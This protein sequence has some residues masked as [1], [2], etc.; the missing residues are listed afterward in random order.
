MNFAFDEDQDRLRDSA[1]R[2]LRDRI[3]LNRL[4]SQG[5]RPDTTYDPS[6]WRDIVALGWPGLL[7]PEEYGGL[8]MSLVDWVVVTEELGRALAPCPYLGTYAGT[9]ALLRAG[10]TDQKERLLPQVVSGGAQL[11]LAWS[12]T[13]QSEDP[14]AVA[15]SVK[16]GVLRGSKRY[17]ID[18]DT[19]THFVVTAR[20]SSGTLGF[21]LVERGQPGVTVE[22]LSWM[23]ITRRVCTVTFDGAR[24]EALAV[25]DFRT[26]WNWIADRLLLALSSE[27]AGGADAILRQTVAYANQRI[28]FGKPIASYQAIKHKCAD[29][30][31]KV[32]SAKALTY[33]C[34]WA[35]SE[36][37]AEGP[38]AASMA[39]SFTSDAYRFCT[40]EAIQI[41]G[42]I[43]FTWE[44]TVHLYFKRAR[45]NAV[46]FGNPAAHRD[47]VIGLVTA[48]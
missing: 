11:A 1:V 40:S 19:A 45:A 2:F 39:K 18:A 43:G 31:T 17:V 44:M 46:M 12:E 42:A 10:T 36:G 27:N 30:L 29:M 32:E 47:R 26:D 3:D 9:L 37:A 22:A 16:N 41:H 48:A 25:G 24:A 5:N 6:L 34:A 14:D 15:A 13:Q 8:G 20:A 21:Y 35:L 38:L 28:Q 4:T 23:D 7:I 33:Y